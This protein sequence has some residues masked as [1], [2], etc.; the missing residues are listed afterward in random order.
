MAPLLALVQELR[1]PESQS[2]PRVRPC[3]RWLHLGNVPEQTTSPLSSSSFL[4]AE[5]EDGDMTTLFCFRLP[6]CL[7]AHLGCGMEAATA[8]EEPMPLLG[9]DR[10]WQTSLPTGFS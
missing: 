2:A 4:K 8:Q 6:P 1:S 5:R 10:A 7:L 9:K 3:P